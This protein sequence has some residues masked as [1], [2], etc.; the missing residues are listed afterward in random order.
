MAE[1]NTVSRLRQPGAGDHAGSPN[2]YLLRAVWNS[3]DISD[4]SGYRQILQR[5]PNLAVRQ[6]PPSKAFN[7]AETGASAARQAAGG[8]RLRALPTSGH[9]AAHGS[10]GGEAHPRHPRPRHSRPLH[11][12]RRRSHVRTRAVEFFH[13]ILLQFYHHDDCKSFS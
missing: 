9:I 6:L 12:P 2:L 7:K 13:V 10:G 4:D 5:A 11:R 1:R 8:A 3:F